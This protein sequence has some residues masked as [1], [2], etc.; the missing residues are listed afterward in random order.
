MKDEKLAENRNPFQ[1]FLMALQEILQLGQHLFSLAHGAELQDKVV[2]LKH[3]HLHH[4]L[5]VRV[6]SHLAHHVVQTLIRFE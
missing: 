2:V 6:L 3:R 5:L 1:S 4:G